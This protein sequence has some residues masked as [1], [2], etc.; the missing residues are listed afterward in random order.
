[1]VQYDSRFTI[2]QSPENTISYTMGLVT[3]KYPGTKFSFD[4]R[5][6]FQQSLESNLSYTMGLMTKQNPNRNIPAKFSNKP[7]SQIQQPI[8][9]KPFNNMNLMTENQH[10]NTKYQETKKPQNYPQNKLKER[11]WTKKSL[12]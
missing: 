8:E 4:H 3:D 2:Q 5:P 1:M 7:K 10:K 12:T 6:M 9:R 11:N